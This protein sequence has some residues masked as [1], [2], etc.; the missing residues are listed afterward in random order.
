MPSTVG[1]CG[2]PA[3]RLTIGHPQLA[4]QIWSRGQKIVIRRHRRRQRSQ[5]NTIKPKVALSKDLRSKALVIDDS[6]AG[7]R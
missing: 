3:L 2:G 7:D 6:D 4:A 5:P 1:L